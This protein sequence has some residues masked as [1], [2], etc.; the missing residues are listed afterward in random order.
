MVHV[1]PNTPQQGENCL[2][3]VNSPKMLLYANLLAPY[4]KAFDFLIDNRKIE[5]PSKGR[6][7]IQILIIFI[8]GLGDITLIMSCAEFN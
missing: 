1:Y 8:T 3:K 4:M 7:Q 5:L 6:L 2:L